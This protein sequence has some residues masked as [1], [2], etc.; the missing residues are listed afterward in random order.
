LPLVEA[1]APQKRKN[2]NVYELRRQLLADI[3]QAFSKQTLLSDH[4]VRGAFA[5]YVDDLKADL[6]SIA[7]SGYDCALPSFQHC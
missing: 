2:G 4:Q 3:S 1:L 6:K 7:A 5:R